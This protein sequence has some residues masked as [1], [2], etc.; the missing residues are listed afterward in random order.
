MA[1]GSFHI[2]PCRYEECSKCEGLWGDCDC[3]YPPEPRIPYI[4]WPGVCVR[5]GLVEP[6]IFMDEE[7]EKYIA[8]M[9]RDVILCR[10]CF[11][12]I[13]ELKGESV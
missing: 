3:M 5:C 1:E 10:K 11:E 6:D 12:E 13:K 8:P 9:H 2:A 7:W 4:H